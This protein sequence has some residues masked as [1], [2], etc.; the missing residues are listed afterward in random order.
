LACT[1]INKLCRGEPSPSQ[2]TALNRFQSANLGDLKTSWATD[3]EALKR[4]L[5]VFDEMFFFG[6]LSQVTLS[7]HDYDS[8][9][10]GGS[11]YFDEEPDVKGGLNMDLSYRGFC[12]E[13]HQ[14][15]SRVTQ[16]DP[17]RTPRRDD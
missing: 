7:L 14:K 4:Y 12:E 8:A 11:T 15:G 5:E 6:S 2:E 3:F 9:K 16:V 10:G 1:Y 17:S 13:F